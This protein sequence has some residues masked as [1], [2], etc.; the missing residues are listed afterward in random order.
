MRGPHRICEFVPVT[1]AAAPATPPDANPTAPVRRA[2]AIPQAGTGRAP[3]RTGAPDPAAPI[4]EL[5][6]TGRAFAR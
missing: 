6:R 2:T 4:L 1:E 3:L 5:P